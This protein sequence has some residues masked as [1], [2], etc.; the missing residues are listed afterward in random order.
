MEREDQVKKEIKDGTSRRSGN[1]RA[2]AYGNSRDNNFG[3]EVTPGRSGRSG[4]NQ[5][6][7]GPGY[8]SGT[9]KQPGSKSGSSRA[10][11]IKVKNSDIETEDSKKGFFSSFKRILGVAGIVAGGA[12]LFRSANRERTSSKKAGKVELHTKQTIKRSPEE[13]YAYWRNLE[14][15]PNFM[16]HIKEV[17]EIDERRSNWTAEVPGGLGTVEWEAV[18]E[19]D[20]RNKY[21]SWRSVADS[22][23]ENWGEVRFEDAPAGKGT[24]VET[25]IS[26]RPPAGNAGEYLAKLLNPAFEKIV[27]KDLEQFKKHMEIG[28]AERSEWPGTTLH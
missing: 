15:L 4:Q 28:G 8:S 25:T 6:V 22:D 12:L 13:L 10:R 1:E 18:I 5:P 16:S 11:V 7:T 17:R 19:Q 14:N 27:K 21:I 9:Y 2:K 26:Y 24:V 23:I 20:L 3:E